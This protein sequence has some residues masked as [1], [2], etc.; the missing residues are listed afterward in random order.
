MLRHSS[1]LKTNL[2]DIFSRFLRS[3][4]INPDVR[5]TRRCGL[6]VYVLLPYLCGQTEDNKEEH[7]A[8]LLPDRELKDKVNSVAG[9][10]FSVV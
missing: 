9:H 7:Q 8:V 2:K 6:H 10:S 1:S 4:K 5:E 3:I